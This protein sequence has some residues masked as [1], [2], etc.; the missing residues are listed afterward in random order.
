MLQEQGELYI[1]HDDQ[2]TQDTPDTVWLNEVGIKCCVVF[3]KDV[4]MRKRLIELEALKESRGAAFIL[5]NGN[6][7]GLQIAEAFKHALP[8][9]KRILKRADRPIVATITKSGNVQVYKT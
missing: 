6:L 7:T 8:Q 1:L 3:S 5:A 9:I 2:F 4:R